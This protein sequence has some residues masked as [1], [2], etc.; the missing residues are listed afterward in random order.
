MVSW[1]VKTRE[2]LV[3][4]VI[5]AARNRQGRA[6]SD[7]IG[8]QSLRFPDGRKA[9]LL[10]GVVHDV[11]DVLHANPA[12]CAGAQLRQLSFN[13]RPL[14]SHLP[15]QQHRIIENRTTAKETK[16]YHG[17]LLRR[18]SGKQVVSGLCVGI[19]GDQIRPP[20]WNGQREVRRILTSL[21]SAQL[22]RHHHC[23]CY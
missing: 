16:V 5:E 14:P 19:I 3:M 13:P 17:H 8:S 2:P 1:H 21:G 7:T 20:V 11:A 23:H 18:V 9:E 10:C 22:H 4:A 12:V 15:P 6:P